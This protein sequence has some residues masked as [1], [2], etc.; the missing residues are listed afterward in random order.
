MA[1]IAR[2]LQRSYEHENSNIL[3]IHDIALDIS[4]STLSYKGKSCDLTKNELRIMHCLFINKN[5]IVSRN[6]LMQHMWD[7]DL[8]VDDNTLTVTSIAYAKTR[9]SAIRRPDCYKARIGIYYL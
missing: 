3:K 1:R 2:V 5:K 8:F 4:K 9:A 7:C 6:E